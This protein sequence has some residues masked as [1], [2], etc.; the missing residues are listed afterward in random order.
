MGFRPL[1]PGILTAYV[2]RRFAARLSLCL[3]GLTSLYMLVEFFE[4]VDNLMAQQLS[5]L[6][7]PRYLAF[8]LPQ[9]LFQILPVG[10]L[11]AI[12]LTL[13]GMAR[14]G[15]LTAMLAGGINLFQIIIP[16]LC[17]CLGLS[18]FAGVYQ[19]YLSPV[20]VQ[21]SSVL[22]DRINGDKPRTKLLQGRIWLAG[23]QGRFFHLQVVDEEQQCLSGVSVFE[24]DEAFRLTRRWDLE[25]CCYRNGFWHLRNGEMWS[26]DR[27][28]PEAE[29]ISQK[30]VAW[31]EE[32]KDFSR[33]QKDPAEMGYRELKQYIR[34][35]QE[36]GYD[37]AVQM[38]DLYFKWAFPLACFIF[39]LLGIPFAARLHRGVRYISMGLALGVS[40]VYWIIMYIGVSM[41]HAGI[42]P[43]LAGAWAGNALFGFL[44]MFLLLRVRT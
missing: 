31:P 39:G 11:M 27:G 4:R 30:V 40:F 26:F 43:P 15:E 41:A 2:G 25:E 13:G 10:V 28:I 24:V 16:L 42:I 9:I 44:G 22:L 20:L 6:I 19:E 12:L 29:R 5:F 18:L 17:I 8:R 32:F 33:L 36:W 38:T 7:M 14:D 1:C 3:A 21:E 35:L 37:T 23:K 34:R